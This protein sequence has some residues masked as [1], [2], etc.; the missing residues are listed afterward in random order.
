MWP[1]PRLW[2]SQHEA[3]LRLC[4]LG[5]G[6]RPGQGPLSSVPLVAAAALAALEAA[7]G[8]AAPLEGTWE[9]ALRHAHAVLVPPEPG[10]ATAASAG[11]SA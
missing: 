10:S 5:S 4:V 2:E 1:L 3:T 7:G 11:A 8:A 9:Q 6:E